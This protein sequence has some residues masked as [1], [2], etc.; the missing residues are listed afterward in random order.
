MI[1]GS[2]ILR[3]SHIAIFGNMKDK[4][5][6]VNIL[7]PEQPEKGSQ[8]RIGKTGQPEGDRQHRTGRTG[9]E[10]QDPRTDRQNRTGR[11]EQAEPG[12]AEQDRQN[13]T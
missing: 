10:D 6:E 11:T 2:L 4:L 3:E 8:N 5:I 13:R 9:Q 12:Q 1:H 7:I